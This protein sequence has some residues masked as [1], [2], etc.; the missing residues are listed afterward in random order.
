M[1]AFVRLL[2]GVVLSWNIAPALAQQS[3]S[4][5]GDAQST[6][7]EA[8]RHGKLVFWVSSEQPFDGNAIVAELKKDYPAIQVQWQAFQRAS[9]LPA[10]EAARQKGTQPDVVFTDNYAQEGP[11][12]ASGQ[13]RKMAGK[14]FHLDR[15]WWTALKDA[16]DHSTADAFLIWLEQPP[17]WSPIKPA[18]PLFKLSD[19][20]EIS[21]IAKEAIQGFSSSPTQ[22]LK[23]T[24]DSAIAPIDWDWV[25]QLNMPKDENQRY[26]PTVEEIGGNTRLAYVVLSTQVQGES[27]FGVLHSFMVL[28]KEDSKWKLL[29]VEPDDSLP[30][31]ENMLAKFDM[32]G[33]NNEASQGNASIALLAPADGERVTRFPKAEISFR[34]EGSPGVLLGIESQ[35]SDPSRKEWSPSVL[36]WVKNSLDGTPTY[37][38]PA[39]FGVGMQP[40]RWRVWSVN[41]AG[42]VTLS[43]WRTVDFTN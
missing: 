36:V 31:A 41:K 1:T 27:V 14:P 37:H 13:V 38:M 43:E 34:Q 10:L 29:L 26:T 28:R 17:D 20:A 32:L 33:L 5:L 23:N 11:L 24:L 19:K 4:V 40:H 39:P 22:T 21:A 12:L 9:F 8:L 15:G 3:A 16:P 7:A 30:R 2:A 42:V 35:F 6:S 18:T 25:R